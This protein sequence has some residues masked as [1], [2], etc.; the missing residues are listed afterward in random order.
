MKLLSVTLG[1]LLSFSV[2]AKE[3][4]HPEINPDVLHELFMSST[5]VKCDVGECKDAVTGGTLA[6]PYYNDGWFVQYDQPTLVRLNLTDTEI[7][8]YLDPLLSLMRSVV[9]ELGTEADRL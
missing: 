6:I 1:V 3:I 5:L 2:Q 7:R 4:Q 8:P 9:I